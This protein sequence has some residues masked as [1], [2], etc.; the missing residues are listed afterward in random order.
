MHNSGKTVLVG[1]FFLAFISLAVA[2]G[3]RWESVISTTSADSSSSSEMSG[4]E[5]DC[6]NEI[7]DDND[8]YTDCDDTDCMYEPDC[9]EGQQSSGYPEYDCSDGFDNDGDGYTDCDDT[10]CEFEPACGGGSSSSSSEGF[11]G[12]DNTDPGEECD[13][14]YMTQACDDDC[15]FP[16]CNDGVYNQFAIGQNYEECEAGIDESNCGIN[17]SCVDCVCVGNPYCGNYIEDLGEECD[18]GGVMVPPQPD[19]DQDCTLPVCGD[20]AYNPAAGEE[21]EEPVSDCR[22]ANERC[23]NCV[24][25]V[26]S[27]GDGAVDPGEE[28]D[29]G[30]TAS[31]DGCSFACKIEIVNECGNGVIDG[32]EKCDPTSSPTGCEEWQACHECTLCLGDPPPPQECGNKIVD[33]GEQCDN[34]AHGSATCD[35]DCTIAVCG[36]GTLNEQAGEFCDDG[37][38]VNGDG[39]TSTCYPEDTPT[40]CGDGEFQPEEGEECEQDSNCPAWKKCVDCLCKYKCGDGIIDTDIGEQ[41]EKGIPCTNGNFCYEQE[42]MCIPIEKCGDGKKDP[43][44]ECDDGNKSDGDGC[45]SICK[46]EY[47]GDCGDGY[48]Q[49]DEACDTSP[50]DKNGHTC[51]IKLPNYHHHQGRCH[52]VSGKETWL[53]RGSYGPEDPRMG[54]CKVNRRTDNCTYLH[55]GDRIRSD[56]LQ[57]ECD[58][59]NLENGDGC[60]VLCIKESTQACGDGECNNGE[61]CMTCT[62]DCGTCPPF[63]GDGACNGTETCDS[64][65][66]D[67]ICPPECPNDKCEDGETCANCADDCGE[68]LTDIC[69]D[70]NCTGTE[71][72]ANCLDDCGICDASFYCGDE[73]C[74]GEETCESCAEDC[75]SCDGDICGDE[76]CTGIETCGSC[77]GDCGSCGRHVSHCGDGHCKGSE[78]C[79]SCAR[80]C[81]SCPKKRQEPECGDG[82]CQRYADES[83]DTCPEDCKKMPICGNGEIDFNEGCA[84]CSA[85]AGEC[86][87]DNSSRTTRMRLREKGFTFC[88]KNGKHYICHEQEFC[89]GCESFEGGCALCKAIPLAKKV[90]YKSDVH[91]SPFVMTG[92]DEIAAE[93]SQDDDAEQIVEKIAKKIE[94]VSQFLDKEVLGIK[95]NLLM[96]I[97]AA[98]L[99]SAVALLYLFK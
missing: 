72:C 9:D 51:T 14:G 17:S 28:C 15:T 65:S 48:L 53:C 30:N 46:T 3:H 78:S 24:C 49:D 54:E 40:S 45:S 76:N 33:P 42:C 62:Q 31:G 97:A 95:L 96:W 5:Y 99:A 4:Y 35:P 66:T 18:R 88:F 22:F 10:D 69:G 71:E 82:A 26:M 7:D 21:C 57:E 90:A 84:N 41:C 6:S 73:T 13:D 70:G 92:E 55:C 81:G 16:T 34:G 8:G 74:N 60:S 75:G 38:F 64:C 32:N 63:C 77:P 58:D 85:D 29:D 12:D 94:S 56:H 23:D 59:G 98:T 61:T 37:N 83:F 47:L 43:G 20:S 50:C 19:C 39:C 67:C 44:E 93:S 1:I 25:V 36:D 68:C 27:C 11:C 80:D 52:D 2:L 86:T 87:P 79:G 89:A 91:V